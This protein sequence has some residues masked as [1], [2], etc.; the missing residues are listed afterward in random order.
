MAKVLSLTCPVHGWLVDYDEPFPASS[1]VECWLLA[2]GQAEVICGRRVCNERL[3][4]TVVE[5]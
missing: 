3:E 4:R 1:P 5:S 2:P